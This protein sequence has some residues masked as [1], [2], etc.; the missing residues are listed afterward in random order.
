[1]TNQ[2]AF[3]S[4]TLKTVEHDGKIWFTAATLAAALE[5][6]DAKSV[7]NIY[8]IATRMNLHPA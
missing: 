5:Y 7:S 6:S 2:I 8:T 4:Q 3:K 1:M